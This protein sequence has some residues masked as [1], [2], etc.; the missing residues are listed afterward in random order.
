MS[1]KE[2]VLNELLSRH[3]IHTIRK[4]V[5]H[6]LNKTIP[7]CIIVDMM[8]QFYNVSRKP[9]VHRINRRVVNRIVQL[10]SINLE[11]MHKFIM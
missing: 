2:C 1:N 6:K 9:S 8:I 11:L 10:H 7:R 4:R 3:N 5:R